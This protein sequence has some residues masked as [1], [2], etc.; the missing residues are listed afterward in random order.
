M[1]YNKMTEN[2]KKAMIDDLSRNVC[3]VVF[4]KRDGSL[5]PM[6][7]TRDFTVISEFDDDYDYDYNEDVSCRTSPD[8]V[9]VFD[10]DKE[11]W[12]SFRFDS[13]EYY[14]HKF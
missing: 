13:I 1:Y 6:T 14:A 3:V 8:V 10:L 12:R 7:C 9:S 5:R 11:E 2:M 4:R